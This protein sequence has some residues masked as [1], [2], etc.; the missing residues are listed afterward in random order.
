VGAT[1]ACARS[2]L[3]IGGFALAAPVSDEVLLRRLEALERRKSRHLEELAAIEREKSKIAQL[4]ALAAELK[5]IVTPVPVEP[6][7]APSDLPL[8]IEALAELFRTDKRSAYQEVRPSSRQQYDKMIRQIIKRC[9]KDKVADLDVRRL[10]RFYDEYANAGKKSMGH[11]FIT[12]L[13]GLAR[14]G[15]TELKNSDCE[16]LAF[17]L[18]G[19][20]FKNVEP[21]K[22]KTLSPEQAAAIIAKANELGL[23]SIALAQAFQFYCRLTQ[24]DV[25]GEFVP[26]SDSVY[27]EIIRGTEKWARG[28]RWNEISD[29]WILTHTPSA[30]GGEIQIR[31]TDYPQVMKEIMDEI[32]RLGR[33]PQSGPIVVKDDTRQPYSLNTFRFL[34]RKA[35]NAAG[36]P[37]TVYN[38]DSR[39]TIERVIPT[40]RRSFKR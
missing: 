13:R 35:A 40:N 20:H 10:Q 2:P 11:G 38:R 33:R 24:K 27:S 36:V 15:M 28:I 19:M 29:D 17:I 31:L 7:E 4:Q 8:T 6:V 32:K 30:G 5:F 14:F 9:G 26:I 21:R 22:G 18:H 23:H 25:V 1:D 12:Q 37:T 16:K 34:W 39:P 3:L